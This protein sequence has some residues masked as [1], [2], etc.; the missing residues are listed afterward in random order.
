MQKKG[1]LT[2]IRKQIWNTKLVR[3]EIYC[4][5]S[6][7]KWKVWPQPKASRAIAF[8]GYWIH[9]TNERLI[10]CVVTGIVWMN[11]KD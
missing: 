11:S 7:N 3:S 2:K 1:F 8:P 6:R 5:Q 9:G 4:K 10:E